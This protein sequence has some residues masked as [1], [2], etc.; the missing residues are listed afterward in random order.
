MKPPQL[1]NAV[2]SDEELE[3]SVRIYEVRIRT[4]D[5]KP[6]G[7]SRPF[8]E[9]RSSFV[10]SFSFYTL[11]FTFGLCCIHYTVAAPE[12]EKVSRVI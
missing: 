5:P 7:F 2:Q 11:V 8:V 3:L 1:R 6:E 12:V 9:H 4:S 10:L